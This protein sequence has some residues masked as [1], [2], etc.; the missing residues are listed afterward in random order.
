MLNK[1]SI[2]F[3]SYDPFNYQSI[4]INTKKKFNLL[5]CFEVLEHTPNP[6]KSIEE[7][8]SFSDNNAVYIIS[9]QLSIITAMMQQG[10]IGHI[11]LQ[12]TAMYLYT[13]RR[14]FHLLQKNMDSI[15]V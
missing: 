8:M 7:L 13:Q 1:E 11:L 4:N 2:Y 12:G 15:I 9:T 3:H 14:Q 5:T 6:I 10:V